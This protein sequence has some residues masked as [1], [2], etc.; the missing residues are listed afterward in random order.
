MR[1]KQ[2]GSITFT[3]SVYLLG[4]YQAVYHNVALAAEEYQLKAVF[5]YKFTKGFVTWPK[6][7]FSDPHSPFLICILGEDPFG[8]IMDEALK[9]QVTVEKRDIIVNRLNNLSSLENCHILFISKSEHN[10][11]TKIFDKVKH[12][13]ILTVSDIEEFT[14][15]GGMVGFFTLQDKVKLAINPCTLV[16]SGLKVNANLLKLA[17]LVRTCQE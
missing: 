12:F 15:Q 4:A 17:K 11:L 13:P 9:G 14:Q 2:L 1:L 3:I 7:I 10:Q 5:V 6:A 16:D 8:Q